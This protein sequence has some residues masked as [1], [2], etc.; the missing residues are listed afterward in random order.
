MNHSL[1]FVL[2]FS[3]I[4]AST[5]VDAQFLPS[6][7]ITPDEKLT[8]KTVDSVNLFLHIFHPEGAVKQGKTAAIVFFFGGGWVGGHP[9]QFYEQAKQLADLGIWAACAEYRVKKK[10][11]TSPFESVKDAKSAIRWIREHANE[12]G[13]NPNEII[14]AGGSA[15]G[16]LAACTGIIEGY[17]EVGENTSISSTPNAMLLYNPVLDTTEKGYGMKKVG[18]DRKTDISPNHHIR[19]GI[20]PTLIFHGKADKT[21]PFEN[22]KSFKKQ[23][24]RS[25]NKCVLKSYKGKGHGFF[26]GVYFRK[27]KADEA[28]YNDVLKKSISFLLRNGFF[29]N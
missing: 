17:E 3:L 29:E 4:I 2:L 23:M 26:N 27:E 7:I 19:K 28:S 10:H 8:Y 13:I 21:V 22:A 25:G 16:H 20:V 1:F 9:K 6:E 14:A 5:T 11:D 12:L 15:G 18:V 24:K